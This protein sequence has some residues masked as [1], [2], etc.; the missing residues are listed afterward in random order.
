MSTQNTSNLLTQLSKAVS[1]AY[2]KDATS[3]GVVF[4]HLRDGQVYASVV[5]YGSEFTKGKQVVCNVYATDADTAL[6]KL[7]ET[8]LNKVV[9]EPNPIDALRVSLNK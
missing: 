2:K 1:Y 7:S 5:R 4:S 3:P 8:F 6:I 9:A